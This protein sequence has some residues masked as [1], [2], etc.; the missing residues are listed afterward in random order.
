M[1]GEDIGPSENSLKRGVATYSI[2]GQT[3]TKFHEFEPLPRIWLTVQ[4]KAALHA[5]ATSKFW[6]AP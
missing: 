3:E 4:D 1:N 6:L 5:S 2:K